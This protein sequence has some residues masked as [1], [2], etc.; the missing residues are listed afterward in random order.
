M[1]TQGKK[2]TG[3]GKILFTITLLVVEIVAVLHYY[4]IAII[5]NV[6]FFSQF[7]ERMQAF[8]VRHN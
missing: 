5:T 7:S 6:F 4:Y 3:V 8:F 2:I 1:V